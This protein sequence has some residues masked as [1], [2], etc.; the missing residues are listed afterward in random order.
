[1]D[2]YLS[3]NEEEIQ[4]LIES[5]QFE[6]LN[7]N[8]RKLV[9]SQMSEDEFKLAALAI[10]ESVHVYGDPE[11]LP[12]VI[13]AKKA[14]VMIPIPLWQAVASV[15]AAVIVSFFIFRQEKIVEV[16]VG[17]GLIAKADTVYVENRIVDTVVQYK[18]QYVDRIIE[19][20]PEEMI[21]I[22][23]DIKLNN[24]RRSTQEV[25]DLD[26]S[27]LQNKGNSMA[28]DKTFSLIEGLVIPN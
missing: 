19:P 12:L 25:A 1:M 10:S 18:T 7:A 13:P 9:L 14:G 22:A 15:A 23:G 2:K 5:K 16:K 3:D 8:E 27:K 4:R 24:E 21:V 11:V 28:N 17:E 26:P 6:A 20:S